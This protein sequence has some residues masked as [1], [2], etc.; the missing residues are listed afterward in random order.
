MISSHYVDPVLQSFEAKAHDFSRGMKPTAT[1]TLNTGEF[2]CHD[3]EPEVR[4]CTP[5][6]R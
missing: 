1:E 2:T 5:T 6:G 3:T 4:I